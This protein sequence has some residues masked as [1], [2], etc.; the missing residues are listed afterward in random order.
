M[1]TTVPTPTTDTG[2]D[3]LP[4]GRQELAPLRDRLAELRNKQRMAENPHKDILLKEY[5]IIQR[6]LDN[7]GRSSI[8][9]KGFS[10]A[11]LGA[12]ALGKE[13]FVVIAYVAGLAVLFVIM[14][15]EVQNCIYEMRLAERVLVIERALNN[16]LTV[17]QTPMIA[18]VL[19]RKQFPLPT[20][21]AMLNNHIF[22]YWRKHTFHY[23]A[24]IIMLSIGV[25]KTCWPITLSSVFSWFDVLT[26][27]LETMVY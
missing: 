25:Y 18:A 22:E 15:I 7:Y 16:R 9:Y 14:L 2:N 4:E 1:V 10:I 19:S 17:R 5:E 3:T 8:A 21:L 26:R 11:V 24:I 20:Q 27:G 12:T 13:Q 6:K 23:A